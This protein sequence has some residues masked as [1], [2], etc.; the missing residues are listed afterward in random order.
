MKGQ[1]RTRAPTL[2]NVLMLP[3]DSFDTFMSRSRQ[4][5]PC[6]GSQ[7]VR[8]IVPCQRQE[9]SSGLKTEVSL[10]D[11]KANITDHLKTSGFPHL[12]VSTGGHVNNLPMTQWRLS[13]TRIAHMFSTACLSLFLSLFYSLRQGKNGAQL[14]LC[15]SQTRPNYESV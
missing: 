10:F 3:T 15:R 7:A 4:C 12:L 6:G 9:A 2:L 11:E 1:K 13:S 5:A 14:Y 8:L